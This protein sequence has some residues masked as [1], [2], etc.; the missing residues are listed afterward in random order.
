M[1][2]L[3]AK[4]SRHAIC[5]THSRW[6]ACWQR[7]VMMGTVVAPSALSMN[8]GRLQTA[9]TRDASHGTC[10]PQAAAG[11]S[12]NPSKIGIAGA[13][14]AAATAGVAAASSTACEVWAQV[15]AVAGA[16]DRR[17]VGS[18][19]H[20]CNHSDHQYP[21]LIWPRQHFRTQISAVK[22]Q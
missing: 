2:K 8:T 9:H 14:A 17:G 1:E 7:K 20:S 5:G 12:T 19:A 13:T 3:C 16:S 11:S 18:A 21:L 6:K 10:R 15:A 4:H 22:R